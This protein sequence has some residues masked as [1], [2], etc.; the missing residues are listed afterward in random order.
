MRIKKMLAGLALSG[1]IIS[2]AACSPGGSGGGTEVKT[3]SENLPVQG[4]NYKYDPN[5]L[6]NDGKP[7]SLDWWAWTNID[8]YQ[9]I[10]DRYTK[11]HPNVKIKVINQ[12]WDDIWTKLPLALRG[13]D[14]PALFN[15]HGSQH[16]NL[17]GFMA[18]YDIPAKDLE[19]DYDGVQYHVIDGKIYYLHLGT[20]SGAI[21]YNTQMWK[22][23]GLTDKD[24][25]KTWNQMREVAKKLTVRDSSNNL[26]RAGFTFNGEGNAMQM[27]LA[28][29][30]GQNLFAKDKKTPTVDNQANLQVIKNL[31]AF[32][33]DGSG[34]KDFGT[35]GTDTFGQGQAAMTYSWGWYAGT[36][37]HDYPDI[38]WSAFPI[39]APSEEVP[40]AY[41]RSGL[42]ATFAINKNA[43]KEQQ[44]VAQDFLKFYLTD[45]EDQKKLCDAYSVFP[46]YKPIANDPD[47]KKNPAIA[48]FRELDRYI[49]PGD[50][51]A[52]FENSMKTMWEDI[53]YNN[54]K[55]EEALKA[56]QKRIETELKNSDFESLESSYP[57][58]QESK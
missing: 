10:A 39:P 5:H 54:V 55:P 1:L 30:Y 27:G 46:A 7:I 29:Q 42:E 41:E 3:A 8:M 2:M 44:S 40:Y 48:A 49:W 12:P 17:I 32:Y 9:N 45:G 16:E 31:L 37:K 50:F 33:Q 57:H 51:P 47:L 43:P 19:K 18:P 26:K 14:G 58:Y 25:P 53:L 52:V 22:E 6:V 20:M 13:K 34:D 36:L 11:L 23:A 35:L 4:V 28:Y 38:K 15:M 56:S 24:I 21:Y